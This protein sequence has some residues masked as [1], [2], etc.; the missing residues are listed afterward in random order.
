M[1]GQDLEAA[2]E[3]RVRLAPHHV[4]RRAP[5]RCALWVMDGYGWLWMVLDGSGWFWM[6]LDDGLWF[7]VEP[8]TCEMPCAVSQSGHTRSA[9]CLR[10]RV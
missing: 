1:I 4:Q 8:A 9:A 5:C 3:V 6:V 2:H 7:G 10:V